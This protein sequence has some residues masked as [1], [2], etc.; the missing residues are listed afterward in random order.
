MATESRLEKLRTKEEQ[1]KEQIKLLENKERLRAK[2]MDTR[3]KILVGAFYIELMEKD[4]D[5][6]KKILAKL[7]GFLTR[8]RDRQL[9][10][11]PEKPKSKDRTED[12]PVPQRKTA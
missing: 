11:L 2:K 4:K 1:L 7:D 10:G 9:F 8:P 3:R 6:K 5:L 12:K